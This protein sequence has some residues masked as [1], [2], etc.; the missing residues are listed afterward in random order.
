M[1]KQCNIIS[2][3]YARLLSLDAIRNRIKK[4]TEEELKQ[5]LEKEKSF[6]LRERGIVYQ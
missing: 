3:I 6:I 1:R 4:L 2:A 5:E